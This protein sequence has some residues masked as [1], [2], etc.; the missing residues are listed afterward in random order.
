MMAQE[1]YC[2]SCGMP[3]KND[4]HGTNSDNSPN[5]E[6]CTHCFQEGKFTDGGLNLSE[7]IDACFPHMIAAHPEMSQETAREHLE[8]FLPTLKRWQ[9]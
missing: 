7:Y 3:M 4:L 8:T 2:Q 6:Y 5:N 1:K 9:K